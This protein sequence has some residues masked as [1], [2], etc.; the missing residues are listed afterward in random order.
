MADKF[1]IFKIA[2]IHLHEEVHTRV[3]AELI[4]PHSKNHKHGQLFLNELMKEISVINETETGLSEDDFS[5]ASVNVEV[6]TDEGRRI[7]M[8]I[9][10]NTLF[11]PVEVKIWAKDQ[12]KQLVDY[13]E[14][15]KTIGK[16]PAV[17][18]LKPTKIPPDKRSTQG[19]DETDEEEFRNIFKQITFSEHIA[20][21]LKRCSGYKDIEAGVR[22]IMI[23]L[24]DNINCFVNIEGKSE[25]EYDEVIK[26]IREIIEKNHK[27]IRFTECDSNYLTIRL[28]KKGMLEFALRI[29]KDGKNKDKI[30]LHIIIGVYWNCL[31]NYGNTGD[32]IE[33]H[34]QD[35]VNLKNDTFKDEIIKEIKDEPNVW[36][37]YKPLSV[38]WEKDS[39][40]VTSFAEKCCDEI[41]VILDKCNLRQN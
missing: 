23:Q 32:Y 34:H 16:V 12:D 7:D 14:Y 28:Q 5:G 40:N 41:S 6:L 37:R 8:V 38:I 29:A 13:F 21:W 17:I 1:N 19:L 9:S 11:I 31:P 27:N 22:E 3:I 30:L 10:S 18:Y 2:K 20:P 26:A 15:A 36:S 4:N 35:V 24:H 25:A 39:F 33:N